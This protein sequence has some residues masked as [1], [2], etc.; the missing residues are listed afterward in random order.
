MSCFFSMGRKLSLRVAGPT[1]TAAKHWLCVCVR[2]HA[3]DS[4]ILWWPPVWPDAP[5]GTNM[6]PAVLDLRPLSRAGP[7]CLLFNMTL[8]YK[9]QIS[10]QISNCPCRSYNYFSSPKVQDPLLRARRADRDDTHGSDSLLCAAMQCW[11]LFRGSDFY[12]LGQGDI[13][14]T[15]LYQIIMSSPVIWYIVAICR[16]LINHLQKRKRLDNLNRQI[17]LII[18]FSSGVT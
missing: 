9:V 8:S 4:C 5:L 3:S 6:K 11:H 18:L 12:P 17:F 7:G 13:L 1:C 14:L 10:L 2:G 16:L 15:C